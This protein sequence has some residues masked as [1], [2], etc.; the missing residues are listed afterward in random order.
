MGR[1]IGAV[2]T[3][4]GKDLLLIA[5][6]RVAMFFTFV[7]PLLF[8]VLFGF[9]F[10]GAMGRDGSPGNLRVMIVDQDNTDV[11]R[12][13]I[14]L[15]SARAGL[16]VWPM[17][18][19]D[20]AK[21]RVRRGTDAAAVVI[22]PGL[23]D[24]L[25][26]LF[27]G[28]SVRVSV[29]ADP[30]RAAE[31]GI[32][33]GLITASGFELIA[34]AVRDGDRLSGILADAR[35]RLRTVDALDPVRR[36]ALEQLINAGERAAASGGFDA[37]A[38][39]GT[40]GAFEPVRVAVLDVARAESDRPRSAFDLTF[41]QAAS[42]G[43]VGCVSGFG[44]SL[45]SERTRGTLVRLLVGPVAR[46]Q[47]LAGKA[48]ACFLAAVVVMVLLRALFALPPFRVAV[49]APWHEAM[50]IGSIAVGFVGVMMLLATLARSEAGAEGFVRAV[51]LLL[52]L[53]GGAGVP[54]M[55]FQGWMR[56]VASGSPFRW[57]ITAL[58]GATW[59]GYSTAEML[60][61]CAVLLCIGVAGVALGV[62][63]FRGWKVG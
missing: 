1:A 12:R 21:D 17:A 51:L 28:D 63:R 29:Y 14:E 37:G 62:W 10:Q 36:I 41:P 20:E 52:A 30:S 34:W 43:L 26:R 2:W 7:F 3:L 47:V 33:R 6:D 61:P 46:W 54:L 11:S 15:L 19:L 60:G 39:G 42:W 44:L 32:L 18:T 57:A 25:E 24:H 22:E 35:A 50:A 48:L 5:R 49:T 31:A 23:A 55:F 45:A 13:F 38:G 59:R 27:S 4:A 8:G 16:E 58:E 40:A 53:L 56:R 9:I